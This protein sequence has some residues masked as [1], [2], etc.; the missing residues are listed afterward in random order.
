MLKLDYLRRLVLVLAVVFFSGCASGPSIV[1]NQAP[2]F[3]LSEFRTFG[4]LNPLSTDNGN[5]RSLNST[6]LV[7]STTRELEAMGLTLSDNN[8]D[9]LVNFILTT[10]DVISSRPTSGVSVSHRRGRYGTWGGYGVAVGTTTSEVAQRTEGTVG[11]DLIDREQ[12][13]LVWEG[14]A[15]GRVT[16]RVRDNIQSVLDSAVSDIFAELAP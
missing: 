6:V 5:V 12:N 13:M 4:F 10:R 9:L 7:A 1:T 16:N 11:I 8:P 14:S 15:R 2:D 3:A